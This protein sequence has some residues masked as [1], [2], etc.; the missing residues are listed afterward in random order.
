M[1]ISFQTRSRAIKRR[2]PTGSSAFAVESSKNRRRVERCRVH[3][4]DVH[5]RRERGRG[6]NA[7]KG[8]ERERNTG[9]GRQR[10]E[11]GGQS[12][13]E[14]GDMLKSSGRSV[15]ERR[16]KENGAVDCV[17]DV[18]LAVQRRRPGVP[19]RSFGIS[20]TPPLI[21]SL[22]LCAPRPVS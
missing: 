20:L 13:Q 18:W 1:V 6:G 2:F 5:R 21:I 17:V 15:T 12:G 4:R 10:I 3:M 16:G 11:G 8:S 9:K 14:Q 22:F 7:W 19:R